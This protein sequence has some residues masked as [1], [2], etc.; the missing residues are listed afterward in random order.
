[1]REICK[2]MC[3]KFHFQKYFQCK[4]EGNEI[5]FL[6]TVV[7]LHCWYRGE[8]GKAKAWL[9]LKLAKVVKGQQDE[10]LWVH[11][12]QKENQGKHEPAG[13]LGKQ[14]SDEEHGNR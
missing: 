5:G 13:E 9:E 4:G 1:M 11:Q 3:L 8:I 14:P 6:S 7:A 10:F 12:W 2:S